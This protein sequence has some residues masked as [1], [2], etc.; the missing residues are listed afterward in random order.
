M[1]TE[2]RKNTFGDYIFDDWVCQEMRDQIRQF[3]GSFGRTYKDWLENA[4]QN[5]GCPEY[6]QYCYV[7][8]EVRVLG[9]VLYSLKKGWFIHAWNNM[10]RLIDADGKIYYV[11][12]CDTFFI[13]LV[14][15]RM[16]LK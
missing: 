2:K 7:L 9:H 15:P 8:D 14:K 16:I 13:K 3:W 1:S 4:K 10:G 6:G 11:S 12:S 5:T